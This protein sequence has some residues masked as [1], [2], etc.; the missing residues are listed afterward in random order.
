MPWQE[1][2]QT[3][4]T[5]RG[6]GAIFLVGLKSAQYMFRFMK[7]IEYVRLFPHGAY[8]VYCTRERW[9]DSCCFDSR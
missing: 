8:L 4:S 5:V 7:V 6:Q 2:L 3:K 1:L 9:V